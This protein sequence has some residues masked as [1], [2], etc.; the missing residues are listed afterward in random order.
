MKVVNAKVGISISKNY[1][2]WLGQYDWS[3]FCTFTTRYA[4]TLPSARR[5]MYRFYDMDDL[6]RSGPATFFWAAEPFDCREGY[7]THALL[8][9][10]AVMTFKF[11]TDCYQVAAGN[12]D[13]LKTEW[14]RVNFRSYNSKLG[15][16]H[17]CGKYIT[18]NLAD[19]DFWQRS[20]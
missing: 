3:Y 4:L 13:L 14:H 15:A 11:L 17:Y 5:L 7:H 19:Y 1:G 18:K 2:E 12:K 20:Y 8:K 10:S 16:A 6:K 9:V